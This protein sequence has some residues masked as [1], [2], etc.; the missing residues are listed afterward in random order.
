M[1][2]LYMSTN[3]LGCFE[4]QL[5]VNR[6]CFHTDVKSQNGMSSFREPLM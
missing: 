1:K 5:H 6:T 2:S 4:M 3:I